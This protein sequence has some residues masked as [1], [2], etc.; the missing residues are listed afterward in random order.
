MVAAQLCDHYD[1]W[2]DLRGRR[3]PRRRRSNGRSE[4]GRGMND[5]QSRSGAVAEFVLLTG[6]LGSGKTTLL[7]DYLSLPDSEDT[8]VI[9]HEAGEINIHGAVMVSG[10]RDPPL[11][12][13]STARVCC[14]C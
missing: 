14:T 2:S 11:A 1:G 8:A 4:A 13:S 7:K 12:L 10:R 5:D 3:A 6:S 9:L